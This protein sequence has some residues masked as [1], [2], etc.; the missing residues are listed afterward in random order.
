MIGGE[1][2]GRLF[3]PLPNL[4]QF[5]LTGAAFLAYGSVRGP[6]PGRPGEVS[7][8]PLAGD[9]SPSA[10][11]V[12]ALVVSPLW[13]KPEPFMSAQAFRL[14]RPKPESGA[15]DAAHP[16]CR[17]ASTRFAARRAPR[18]EKYSRRAPAAWC[19]VC[20]ADST[21]QPQDC[22]LRA[23]KN[24]AIRPTR[25]IVR[26]AGALRPHGVSGIGELFAHR[27]DIKC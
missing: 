10:F 4:L 24:G 15:A 2:G 3:A 26:P 20:T 18:Y 19:I 12:R 6:G 13:L 14:N 21:K 16:F 9:P 27:L 11:T 5:W 25:A 7:C 8:S 17:G 1:R 23:G 22:P